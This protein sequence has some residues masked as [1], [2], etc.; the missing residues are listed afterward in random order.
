MTANEANK[1]R[2]AMRA[3]KEVI[4]WYEMEHDRY[5]RGDDEIPEELR[6][7]EQAYEATFSALA[8]VVK[9]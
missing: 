1:V 5:E 7:A 8:K 3:A 9:P 6:E 4:D 2:A